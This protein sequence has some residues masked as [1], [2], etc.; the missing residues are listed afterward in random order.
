M[1]KLESKL[2]NNGERLVPYVS[3]NEGELVRHR[4]SY[5]FFYNVINYD[6]KSTSS[7]AVSIIDL[8]FGSGWGSAI[9]SGIEKS[10]IIGVDIGREC[11]TYAKQNYARSNIEYII[12]DA[13][14]FVAR[15]KAS[16]YVVSRGVLE[17]IPDGLNLIKDFK[18]KKRVIIDVPY[19]EAAGNTH[20]VLLG[21]TDKDFKLYQNCEIFYEDVNGAIY[22]DYCPSNANMMMVVISKPGLKKVGDIFDFPILPI[23]SQEKEIAVD[24]HKIGSVTWLDK[25]D[26]FPEVIKNIK[27]ALIGYD[28]GAGIVPHDYLEPIIY[29][30]CEPYE[31]YVNVLAEKISGDNEKI[32]VVQKKDWFASI[33]NLKDNS[34]DSVYL[35]DVI[36]H[37]P[38]QEG[39]KLLRMTE[40]VARKQIVIFTPLGYIKQEVL[41]GGKDAW[42]L[43]GAAYQEHKSGWMPRDFDQTWDIFACKNYH[44]FN[45]IGKRLKNPFG[46]LWAI[47]N[48]NKDFQE[49]PLSFDSIP[50]EIKAELIERLPSHYFD[51]VEKYQNERVNL[52]ELQSAY[53][54]LVNS[55]AVKYANSIKKILKK[56]G[57]RRYR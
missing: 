23:R 45:N 18:Y 41:D 27:P 51:V 49:T 5:A 4:S 2:Y 6:Q 34:I 7:K 17:H 54:G 28:I 20:H 22:K 53:L 31:E 44:T 40:R 39:K 11:E 32:Y 50:S 46:A 19:N 43:N 16:D 15:M 33:S 48:M 10:K 14:T 55:R 56:I 52:Q 21:L 42:G 24:A 36:E 37:L 25:K 47:K 13:R 1:N 9:L 26:L 35:I 29:V 38:K 57:V 30:C 8:G 3:H 12:Q